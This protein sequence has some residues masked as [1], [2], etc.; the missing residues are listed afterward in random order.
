[1]DST[2]QAGPG[3]VDLDA[4]NS[5]DLIDLVTRSVGRSE[6]LTEQALSWTAITRPYISGTRGFAR[7][8]GTTD[9]VV[10]EIAGP[11]GGLSSSKF[12]WTTTRGVSSAVQEER[13][14]MELRYS[15]TR[16]Q[17]RS[18]SSN[19]SKLSGPGALAL[20]EKEVLE[21]IKSNAVL[22]ARIGDRAHEVLVNG[23]KTLSTLT[24]LD[25]T[26]GPGQIL[27]MLDPG[28]DLWSE[29]DDDNA[30]KTAVISLG[31]RA[32]SLAVLC[33]LEDVVLSVSDIEELTGLSKRGVQ[34]LLARM[35]KANPLL[36]QK[37]R[38][39]RSFEYAIY[40]ASCFRRSGDW[41]DDCYDRDLIRKARAAKDRVVQETSARRGTGPGYIAYLHST[42]NPRRA[43]YLEAN[44]LPEDADGAWRALVE[45]GDEMELYAYL[46]A[47]EAEAG[48]VP[49]TPEV[50]TEET[51]VVRPAQE[52]LGQKEEFMALP[53]GERQQILAA[54]RAR[55]VGV[56]V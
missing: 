18:T 37:V 2:H 44:P 54:M 35:T 36:V 34:A 28:L 6:V 16:T 46:R 56:A 13:D 15:D 33:G 27:T 17:N 5:A 19:Y 26:T 38:K 52:S 49:S 7:W 47:Q 10:R 23:L 48:P 14:S 1:M 22:S 50:L 11:T 40:W 39:G 51:A 45:A 4:V 42:A 32:W 21:K 9:K 25:C 29:V 30:V 3:H 20:G 24:E 41:W 31:R 55:V 8:T 53:D 43:E 12:L